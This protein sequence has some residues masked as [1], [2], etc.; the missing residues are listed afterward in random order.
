MD[1]QCSS[2]LR[3][4]H[5]GN[6]TCNPSQ[7]WHCCSCFFP[8]LCP[9]YLPVGP[10]CVLSGFMTDSVLSGAAI[11]LNLDSWDQAPVPLDSQYSP[12][13]WFICQLC[14]ALWFE[15]WS[16]LQ[17]CHFYL[18]HI[19]IETYHFFSQCHVKWSNCRD[20]TW[21]SLRNFCWPS[22]PLCFLDHWIAKALKW[23]DVSPSYV[24]Q[25]KIKP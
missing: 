11:F 3:A 9:E 17:S 1:S 16:L 15:L 22:V 6:A 2:P 13:L 4:S 18:S 12:D 19:P 14:L 8:V 20:M 7:A 24:I 25:N 5:G 21:S 23:Y 10:F